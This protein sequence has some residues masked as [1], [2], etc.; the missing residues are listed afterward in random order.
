MLMVILFYL[1]QR[2]N[3]HF[4]GDLFMNGFGLQRPHHAQNFWGL[5]CRGFV[6]GSLVLQSKGFLGGQIGNYEKI[7]NKKSNCVLFDGYQNFLALLLLQVQIY[8][9]SNIMISLSV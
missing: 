6:F 9:L 7:Y 8:K 3:Q 2:S 1:W 4:F 5:L